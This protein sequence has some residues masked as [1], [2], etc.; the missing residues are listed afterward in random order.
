MRT[1]D[2]NGMSPLGIAATLLLAFA[3]VAARPDDPKAKAQA[4][5]AESERLIES[6][7]G[8]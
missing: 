3:A 2:T 6:F 7:E 1:R 5:K 4:G 8:P